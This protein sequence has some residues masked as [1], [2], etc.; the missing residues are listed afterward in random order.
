MAQT[1]VKG[2]KDGW[3]TELSPMWPGMGM[4]LKVEEV[5]FTGRSQFQ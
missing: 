4:S 2:I 5:L 1:E 3:F